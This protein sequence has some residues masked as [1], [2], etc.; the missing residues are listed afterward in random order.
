MKARLPGGGWVVA[1]AMG[2]K[3]FCSTQEEAEKV[4]RDVRSGTFW[5]VLLGI[6]LSA[7]LILWMVPCTG[8]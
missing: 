4:E 5:G 3:A 6:A 2:G 1:V 8:A 7:A